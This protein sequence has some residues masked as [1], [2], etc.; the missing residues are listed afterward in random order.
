MK[1]FCSVLRSQR[2]LKLLSCACVPVL[3]LSLA[4]HSASAADTGFA[5]ETAGPFDYNDPLNWVGQVINGVWDDSLTLTADQVVTFGADTTLPSGLLIDYAGASG[6]DLTL[7][8]DGSTRTITLGGDIVV[9]PSNNQT[10][11]FGSTTAGGLNVALGGDRTFSVES[12][13]ILRFT[14]AITGGNIAM[15]ATGGGTL[16]LLGQNATAVDSTITVSRAAT[17]SFD[18]TTN[19][20]VGP[21]IR[22]GAVVLNNGALTVAGNGTIETVETI[23]GTITFNA[24]AD[25]LSSIT[26]TPGTRNTRLVADGIVRGANSAVGLVRGANLGATEISSATSG[27]NIQLGVA[28]AMIGGGGTTATNRSI[29]PWLIG[30]TTSSDSGSTFVTY[31][32]DRGLRPLSTATEFVGAPTADP[33]D[34]LR[35][36]TASEINGNA[37]VNSLVVA[38][39]A[40]LG[41]TGILTV[42]SG[43]VLVNAAVSNV[44]VL[45][46][47]LDFGSA[48]GHLGYTSNGAIVNA[49]I[50]GTGGMVFYSANTSSSSANELAIGG[51]NTYSG[52]TTVLGAL[53]VTNAN[54]LPNGSRTGDVYLYGSINVRTDFTIN[55]L[56][57]TGTVTR[58]N[59][60]NQTLTV[61]DNNA[62]GNFS[63]RIVNF[64]G[65]ALTK[66]GAGTQVLSGTESEYDGRTIVRGGVLEFMT[67]TNAGVGNPTP[68]VLPSSLGSPNSTTGANLTMDGGTLRHI[69]PASSTDRLFRIGDTTNGG[70]GTIEAS[71]TGPLVFSNTAAVSYGTAGTTSVA[72]GRTFVLGG[73]NTELNTV[74]SLIGNNGSATNGNS[75]V[76]VVKNGGGTWLLTNSN[77]YTGTTTV[78]GGTLLVGGAITG[79]ASVAVNDTATLGGTGAIASPTTVAD[80]GTLMGGNGLAAAGALSLGGNVSLLDGSAIRL[81]L[82]ANGDHST[83]ARTGGTWSFS[84]TQAFTF[85]DLGAQLGT[86]QDI[87]TGLGFDPGTAGW[88]IETPGYSGAFVYDGAN[89]DLELTAVPE[90][91]TLLALVSGLGVL[92]LRRRQRA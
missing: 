58:T 84:A 18:S 28:P 61:G 5:F 75:M 90:P 45:S 2:S 30:G 67:I 4:M 82:G 66:I 34:N 26:I 81:T 69:G 23:D 38:S 17:L 44:S 10:V 20:T 72:Q 92:A 8:G 14:S 31:D 79:S 11:T 47:P 80:G 55:G 22:T 35:V 19:G 57:G 25:R 6:M 56:N 12:G 77:T 39:G 63:G 40:T 41:G 86:F 87:I 33:T 54:A 53:G 89:I 24:Y 46:T 83:L 74:A 3:S 71:G 62:N 37:T 43:A 9:T 1:H 51:A 29:V 68:I 42:T 78:N 15:G 27:G 48:T 52:D 91:S 49:P 59:S 88:T 64:G 50:S 60:G 70:V 76:S 32:A 36:T 16:R 13:D 85:I 21:A 65:V 7:R 73:S